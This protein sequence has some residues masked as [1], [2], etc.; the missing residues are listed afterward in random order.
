MKW[1]YKCDN[2]KELECFSKNARR[3]DGHNNMCRDCTQQYKKQHYKDNKQVYKKNVDKRREEIT[4][5][6]NSI[7]QTL[8]CEECGES[9]IATLDFHHEDA[10]EKDFNV[11]EAVNRGMCK[12]RIEEEIS[13]CKV[14]C[15]NCHR[16][17]HW[18]ERMAHSSIG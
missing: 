16:I 17:H 14:W 7:K 6:L 11:S 8:K 18:R 5:W 13:K 2:N 1:C 12:E 3:A 4:V 9:H 10:K 15:S